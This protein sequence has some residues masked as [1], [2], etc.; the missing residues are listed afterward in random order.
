MAPACCAAQHTFSRLPCAAL[1]SQRLP[2]PYLPFPFMPPM[3][4]LAYTYLAPLP[5]LHTLMDTSGTMRIPCAWQ[6]MPL[7][8]TYSN[9]VYT[10]DTG[11]L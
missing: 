5:P 7:R 11:F 8:H 4:W 10:I 1:P 6:H 3:L 9:L 2:A